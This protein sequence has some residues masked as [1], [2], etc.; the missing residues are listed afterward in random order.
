MFNVCVAYE[1]HIYRRHV[2]YES[3]KY[4][5][6]ADLDVPSFRH[7]VT[8]LPNKVKENKHKNSEV[9]EKPTR[10]REQFLVMKFHQKCNHSQVIQ[11]P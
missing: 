9:A 5:Y 1:Y 6:G 2:T 10:G 4:K 11:Q 7:V 8:M 3:F